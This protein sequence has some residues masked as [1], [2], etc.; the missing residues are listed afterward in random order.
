METIGPLLLMVLVGVI[1][2]LLLLGLAI[3]LGYVRV[4]HVWVV[5]DVKQESLEEIRLHGRATRRAM[6]AET[7][8][9]FEE[10]YQGEVAEIEA[11]YELHVTRNS[12]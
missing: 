3:T 4:T 9:Y 5:P 7:E 8:R 12:E 11:Q 2:L 6:D 10:L 1:I